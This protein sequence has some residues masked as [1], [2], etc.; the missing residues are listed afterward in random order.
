[1]QPTIRDLTDILQQIAPEHLAERWDN[2]GLLVGDPS[3]PIR[4]V[5]LALDP[6]LSLVS[7]AVSVGANVVL[8][9]HPVIFH[10]LKALRLDQSPGRLLQKALAHDIALIGC[11]TN[12]DAVRHGVS[13]VLAKRLGLSSLTPLIPGSDPK[14]P[15]C[16][17]GRM[18]QYD[19]EKEG[20]SPEEFIDRLHSALQ[21]P[22][23]LEA[24]P[25]PDRI[26]RVAVCGGSCSDFAAA[27]LTR[28]A[29]VFVTSEI[30]H[31]KARWAEEQ[32]FW[33]VDGGHFATE[34]LAIPVLKE[35]LEKQLDA[36]GIQPPLHLAAQAPPLTLIP[37]R[38]S[39]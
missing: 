29:D 34:N 3:A 16:G 10:P 15:E 9:H 21:P 14:R 30:K 24:G 22:W 23:L 35:Q 20:L 8:T 12:L 25:R 17:L 6:T 38:C 39:P 5:L 37:N 2:V 13:D 26:R 28:E 31:D 4:G 33:M 36:A 19:K 18:G 11:H 32:R 27:A 1:M 7:Q